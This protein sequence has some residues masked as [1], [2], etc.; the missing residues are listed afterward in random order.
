MFLLKSADVC[1]AVNDK[2]EVLSSQLDD[3]SESRYLLKRYRT[4]TSPDRFANFRR[5]WLRAG[6]R[7]RRQLNFRRLLGGAKRFATSRNKG[8]CNRSLKPAVVI[9]GSP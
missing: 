9:C 3:R 1:H 5:W 4:S 2:D 8:I 7:K 6:R